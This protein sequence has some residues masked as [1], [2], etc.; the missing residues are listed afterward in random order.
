ME[1]NEQGFQYTYSAP[2]REEVEAIRKKY[3]PP[4]EDKMATL[5][6]LDQGATRKAT[7]AAISLGVPFTLLFGAGMSMCMVWTDALLTPGIVLGVVGLAGMA[8][9]LPVYHSVL[10]KQR[11]R[12]APQVLQ[13]ADELT[14]E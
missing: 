1:Q 3:L 13:L 2:Q 7:V 12:I 11:A 6:R 10:K 8:L 5:R 14:R 4:K 9:A